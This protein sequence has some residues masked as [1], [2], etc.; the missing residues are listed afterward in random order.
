M[1]WHLAV[2]GA[3]M[4]K[5][6]ADESADSSRAKLLR[7]KPDME[8]HSNSHVDELQSDATVAEL[9]GCICHRPVKDYRIVPMP[10]VERRRSS[11]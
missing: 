10:A 8:N 7:E 6:L 1:R 11:G 5:R 3:A 4:K 2:G 9:Y